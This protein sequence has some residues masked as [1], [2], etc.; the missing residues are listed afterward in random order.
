MEK[1]YFTIFFLNEMAKFQYHI[2]FFLSLFFFL[3]LFLFLSL[4]LFSIS[5]SN[6]LITLETFKDKGKVFKILPSR[7]GSFSLP[8]QFPIIF[9]SHSLLSLIL[10]LSIYL[11]SSLSPLP[12]SILISIYIYIYISYHTHT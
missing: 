9:I 2:I 10:S 1:V 7:C 11:S 12:Y 8:L 6:D 5:P 4:S 3:F